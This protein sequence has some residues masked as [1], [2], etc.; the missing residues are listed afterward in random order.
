VRKKHLLPIP[1]CFPGCQD[2]QTPKSPVGCLLG[3]TSPQSSQLQPEFSWGN[4]NPERGRARA[5][6]L[7]SRNLPGP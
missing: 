1:R 2:P 7:S 3:Y 5:F 6:M 4:G